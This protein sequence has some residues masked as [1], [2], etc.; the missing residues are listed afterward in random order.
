MVSTTGRTTRGASLR[1]YAEIAASVEFFLVQ[2]SLEYLLAASHKTLY[3]DTLAIVLPVPLYRM[4]SVPLCAAGLFKRVRR[5]PV[6]ASTKDF[7]VR[8]HL[9]VLPVKKLQRK[10]GEL[11]ASYREDRHPADTGGF[12][13]SS[14]TARA[15]DFLRRWKFCRFI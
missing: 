10:L 15:L 1:F 6:P 3:W 4:E 8:L 5:F 14:P 13:I 7:F 11:K 12:N 9:E 2:F